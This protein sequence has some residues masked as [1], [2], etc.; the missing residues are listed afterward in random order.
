MLRT[1]IRNISLVVLC[2][3]VLPHLLFNYV[4]P[5]IMEKRFDKTMATRIIDDINAGKLFPDDLGQIR[6]PQ[7]LSGGR[8]LGYVYVDDLK[9]EGFAVF[10]PT[11]N[12]RSACRG[13]LYVSRPLS[14]R[15]KD[16]RF[17]KGESLMMRMW[18]NPPSA[19][20]L[21]KPIDANWYRI[22]TAND[23]SS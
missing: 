18:G 4:L 11:L 8:S 7:W 21:K 22:E 16:S 3:F 2:L 5:N 6:V 1:L 14:A 23:E 15:D 19:V 12:L 20:S 9:G 13:Y 17:D 10:F